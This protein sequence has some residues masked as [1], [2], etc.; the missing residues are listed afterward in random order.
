MRNCE[1]GESSR[2]CFDEVKEFFGIGDGDFC[3]LS[4]DLG[5]GD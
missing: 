4:D 1:I 3:G 2:V 5:G